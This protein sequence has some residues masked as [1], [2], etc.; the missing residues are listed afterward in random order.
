MYVSVI[1]RASSAVV[2]ALVVVFEAKIFAVVVSGVAV[3][4]VVITGD[5]V[6]VCIVDVVSVVN[7]LLIGKFEEQ[8]VV[9]CAVVP[10]AIVIIGSVNINVV[11]CMVV[12]TSVADSVVAVTSASDLMFV[13]RGVVDAVESATVSV[14]VLVCD[15]NSVREVDFS[16]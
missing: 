7:N 12:A 1:F 2:G 14:C 3:C 5:S 8:A 16:V 15:V 10:G 11:G 13:I 6:V 4:S 9:V